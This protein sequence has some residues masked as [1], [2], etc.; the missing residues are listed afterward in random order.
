MWQDEQ[1]LE[2]I[3]GPGCAGIDQ[4]KRIADQLIATGKASHASLGV[5]VSSDPTTHGAVVVDLTNGGPAAA[6]GPAE[7]RDH[8][9]GVDQ[10]VIDSADALVAAVRSRSPGDAVTLTYTD[11]AGGTKTLQITLGVATQ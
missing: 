3:L 7:G 11:P 1:R 8:H 10:R 4:A 6:V 5:R 2:A 9:Q